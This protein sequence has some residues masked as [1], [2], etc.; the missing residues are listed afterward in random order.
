MTDHEIRELLLAGKKIEAIKRYRESSGLGLKES[1]DAIELVE[2]E[3]RKTGHI[4]QKAAGCLG[5]ILL[6]LFGFSFSQVFEI[7]FEPVG[8]IAIFLG[9]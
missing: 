4:P 2:N 7:E 8:R 9:K 3:L 5:L 1:K 6:I